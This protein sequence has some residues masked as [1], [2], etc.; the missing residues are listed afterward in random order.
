LF[1]TGAALA[2]GGALTGSLLPQ[3]QA[4]ILSV[5]PQTHGGGLR[6]WM[7]A[8]DA[9]FLV[10]GTLAVL[11]VFHFAAHSEEGLGRLWGGVHRLATS[12]GRTLIM[13]TFGALLAGAAISTYVVLH[14]RLAFLV[15]DWLSLFGKMGL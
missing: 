14:G 6:G 11:N 1:G 8:I 4:S 9:V 13:I 7:L 10:L 2:L 12:F 5:S 3:M 15:N